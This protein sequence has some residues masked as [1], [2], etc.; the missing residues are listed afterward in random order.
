MTIKC[1]IYFVNFAQQFQG[2]EEERIKFLRNEMWV[3][4]NVGSQCNVD[5]DKVCGSLNFICAEGYF[6]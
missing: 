5:E 3:Y 4:S 1:F 6:L 2:M